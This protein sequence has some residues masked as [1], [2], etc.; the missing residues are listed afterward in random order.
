MKKDKE[1][2]RDYKIVKIVKKDKFYWKPMFRDDTFLN[3][4]EWNN[5]NIWIEG[6]DYLMPAEYEHKFSALRRI[7]Q[8]KKIIEILEN[9][10]YEIFEEIEVGKIKIT[11]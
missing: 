9:N 7:I 6:T 4:K 5:L 3:K 10:K 11:H 8:D 2:F 1:K